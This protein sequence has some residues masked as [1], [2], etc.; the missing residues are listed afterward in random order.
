VRVKRRE[1][2]DHI[3][4]AVGRHMTA[5]MKDYAQVKKELKQLKTEHAELKREHKSLQDRVS[6]HLPKNTFAEYF[7]NQ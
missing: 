4:N 5:M 3:Q 1:M 2:A 7:F 6:K